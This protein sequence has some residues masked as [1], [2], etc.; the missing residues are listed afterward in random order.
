VRSRVR[1][2]P[3]VSPVRIASQRRF[4]V[5][6][7]AE[8]AGT[9]SVVI[10]IAE[11]LGGLGWVIPGA[12]LDAALI[13][14]LLGSF[15]VTDRTRHAKLLP[16]LALVALLRVLSVTAAIPQLPVATWYVTVGG[17]LL[18]AE[19]TTLRFVG[20]AR[21][22]LNL[23]VR[24]PAFDAMVT[25]MGVPAGLIGFF[26]LRP[27]ALLA[28]AGPLPILGGIVALVVFAALP[29]ELLFRGLLQGIAIEAFGSARS[30]L[31]YAA[32][33]SGVMYIGSGS[34]PYTVAVGA[35]GVLVGA[36]IVRGASVWGAAASHGL[37]LVGMAFFWPALLG[38]S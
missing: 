32:V 18:V 22:R 17:A 12:M 5:L 13:P 19:A 29:E 1:P 37:A 21:R 30:G 23:V 6:G 14:I 36:A 2:A 27:P 34:L 33:M 11:L 8:V 26:I 3:V 28:G 10:L 15:V 25:V 4:G 20:D 38:P 7:G 24:R 9:A 31:A 35:Y 16:I